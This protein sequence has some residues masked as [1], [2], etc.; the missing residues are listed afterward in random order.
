V[1]ISRGRTP[2]PGGAEMDELDL[3]SDLLTPREAAA[4]ARCS[5]KTIYRFATEGHLGR[6]KLGRLVRI[7][8]DDLDVYLARQHEPPS[9]F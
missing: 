4:L 8:R 6:V 3:R 5:P 7:R 9:L 2:E 1:P